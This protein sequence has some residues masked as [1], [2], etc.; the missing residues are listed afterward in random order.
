MD[1][2]NFESLNIFLTVSKF[3]S[4][5]RASN[6]LYLDSSTISKKI[7][8]LE[9]AVNRQLFART[10]QGVELTSAGVAFRKKR[11]KAPDQPERADRTT[12]NRLGHPADRYSGQ[13]RRLPLPQPDQQTPNPVQGAQD[14]GQGDRISPS[15]QRGPIGRNHHQ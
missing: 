13:H 9:K 8:Q 5:S 12:D 14:F 11:S 2:F 7:R 1:N 15:L 10:N 6:Y 3:R 4:F